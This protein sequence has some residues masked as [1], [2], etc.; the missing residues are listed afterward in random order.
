MDE[1]FG[2]QLVPHALKDADAARAAE[3]EMG[4]SM[5]ERANSETL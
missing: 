4:I 2:D 3:K 5:V 1:L